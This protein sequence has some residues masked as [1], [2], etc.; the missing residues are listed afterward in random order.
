MVSSS[1]TSSRGIPESQA[2]NY[3]DYLIA[4]T[5]IRQRVELDGDARSYQIGKLATAAS[6]TNQALLDTA[7]ANDATLQAAVASSTDASE[8]AL[9]KVKYAYSL[10]LGLQAICQQ[11]VSDGDRDGFKALRQ[12]LPWQIRASKPSTVNLPEFQGVGMTDQ[13]LEIANGVISTFERK[14]LTP[15]EQAARLE[16]ME[17][18]S[19]MGRVKD[20]W[21][22]LDS[23]FQKQLLPGSVAGM[24]Q[25]LVSIYAWF[26]VSG[27]DSDGSFIYTDQ[28]SGS[29][30]INLV[31]DVVPTVTWGTR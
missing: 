5:K 1:L 23:F 26:E 17:S 25:R 9:E 15:A 7:N 14:L 28:R 4:S 10:N 22:N 12:L 2:T 13:D 30:R 11:L 24:F 16:A 31:A 8:A 20:N 18:A 19:N 27:L 21:A 3:N 6:A 29:T